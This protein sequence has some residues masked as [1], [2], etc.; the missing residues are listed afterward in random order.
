[1]D[2]FQII[3]CDMDGTLAYSNQEAVKEMVE[4][5]NRMAD[6]YILGI[7]S[8]AT[9][10]KMKEQVCGKLDSFHYVISQSGAEM[11]TLGKKPKREN[12]LIYRLKMDRFQKQ[13]IRG[14]IESVGLNPKF[15]CDKGGQIT[16]Y[17]L[18][19]K[20]LY[21]DK[22]LADP[23]LK[24]R[25]KLIK[26][27]K[28]NPEADL[29][30]ITIG[31]TTAIDFLPKGINKRHG[32]EFLRKSFD[33]EIQKVLFIGDRCFP[34]GNDWIGDDYKYKQVKNPEETLEYLKGVLDVSCEN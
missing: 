15:I 8:G 30:D 32:V 6:R 18:G 1:M 28:K 2:E 29:F 22:I 33:Y 16:Y 34:G 12:K 9:Y 7:I 13:I 21:E 23:K 17:L 24:I 31:G 26:Q 10:K 25:K 20:A 3:I 14:L 27:I 4:V 11:H 5:L 19:T